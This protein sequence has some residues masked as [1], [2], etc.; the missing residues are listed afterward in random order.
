MLDGLMHKKHGQIY[1][2]GSGIG[3]SAYVKAWSAKEG[4]IVDAYLCVKCGDPI[5][6]VT[7][8]DIFEGLIDACAHRECL[9]KHRRHS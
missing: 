4:K 1:F 5:I 3:S 6:D 7:D 8:D 9:M 2:S